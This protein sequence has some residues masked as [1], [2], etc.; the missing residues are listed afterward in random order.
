MWGRDDAKRRDVPRVALI[1]G[2]AGLAG[3]WGFDPCSSG[4]RPTARHPLRQFYPRQRSLN[5]SGASSAT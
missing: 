4:V 5:R 2:Y 1:K 3:R